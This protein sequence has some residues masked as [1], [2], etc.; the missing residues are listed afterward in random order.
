[1]GLSA[2]ALKCGGAIAWIDGTITQIAGTLRGEVDVLS[3][4]F[5]FKSPQNK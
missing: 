1:M 2:A 4:I 5:R 3:R